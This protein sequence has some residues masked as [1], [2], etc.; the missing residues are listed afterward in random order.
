MQENLK[1]M[2]NATETHI[3]HEKEPQK[4]QIYDKDD[5]EKA[6]SIVEEQVILSVCISMKL[7]MENYGTGPRQH[8]LAI[9]Y[10]S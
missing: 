1:H 3:L 5:Y 10:Y 8:Q 4:D 2:R 9:K 6:C 7:V